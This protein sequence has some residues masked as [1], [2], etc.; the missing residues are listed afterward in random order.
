VCACVRLLLLHRPYRIPLVYPRPH[1][2]LSTVIIL[3]NNLHR[4]RHAVNTVEGSVPP[5]E[6]AH[7]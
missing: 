5:S 6:G 4:R 1:Q 3:T 7:P 2:C